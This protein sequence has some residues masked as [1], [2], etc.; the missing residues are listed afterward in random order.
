[1]TAAPSLVDELGYLLA[2]RAVDRRSIDRRLRGRF[3]AGLERLAEGSDDDVSI[4]DI[5][6]GVGSTLEHLLAWGPPRGAFRIRFVDTDPAM[7]TV[8]HSRVPAL[9]N[10]HGLSASS[11]EVFATDDGATTLSVDVRCADAIEAIEAFDPDVLVGMGFVDLLAPD[12]IERLALAVEQLDL[13]YFPITFDG[14]TWFEPV[15]DDRLDT[16]IVDRYHA[17]MRT[18]AQP[19]TPDAGRTLLAALDG[20]HTLVGGS[21]WVVRPSDGHFPAD[22]ATVVRHVLDLFEGALTDDPDLAPDELDAW[23]RTR[24]NQVRDGTVTYVAHQLDLLT[25]SAAILG[26]H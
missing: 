20:G 22:E 2:K 14:G 12:R 16:R 18:R 4:L 3:V 5:G 6:C 13:A 25:G 21:D 19:G 24:R 23:L 26:D 8:T 17:H 15:L 1:M 7:V 11:R 10:A 9:C